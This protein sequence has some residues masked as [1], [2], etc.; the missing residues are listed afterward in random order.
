MHFF[1]QQLDFFHSICLCKDNC[2]WQNTLRIQ[3]DSLQHQTSSWRLHLRH[4]F[5]SCGD[6]QWKINQFQSFL[7]R[8]LLKKWCQPCFRSFQQRRTNLT[9][10][11]QLFAVICKNPTNFC[12]L[13]E[14]ICC[15]DQFSGIQS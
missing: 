15:K 9:A 4:T 14:V 11:N 3:F 6:F 2:F 10:N 5:M 13:F 7:V 12:S 1:C 8:L